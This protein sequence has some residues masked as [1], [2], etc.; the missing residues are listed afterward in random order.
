MISA[1][2]GW[3]STYVLAVVL[4]AAALLPDAVRGK[5]AK[6]VAFSTAMSGLSAWVSAKVEEA[7]L[8]TIPDFPAAVA[9]DDPS[10]VP[11]Y[12][13]LAV[14]ALLVIVSVL[15]KLAKK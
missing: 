2:D 11:L 5:P 12:F 4:L 13:T 8:S 15:A 10:K 9:A 6:V 1:I 7:W 3:L 14:A